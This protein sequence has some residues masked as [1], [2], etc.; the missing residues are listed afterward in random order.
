MAVMMQYISSVSLRTVV[1]YDALQMQWSNAAAEWL[2]GQLPPEEAQR[3][4]RGKCTGGQRY[5]ELLGERI[6]PGV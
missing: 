1:R 4:L 2:A 3:G 6:F 5:D